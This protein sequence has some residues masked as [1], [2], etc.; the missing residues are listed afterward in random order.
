MSQSSSPCTSLSQLAC[1]VHTHSLSYTA[2]HNTHFSHLVQQRL[3]ALL[4]LSSALSTFSVAQSSFAPLVDEYKSRVDLELALQAEYAELEREGGGGGK[5]GRVIRLLVARRG[6]AR[7]AREEAEKRVVERYHAVSG[8]FEREWEEG[9]KLEERWEV[10]LPFSSSPPLSA[11][12]SARQLSWLDDLHLPFD[13]HDT[14]RAFLASILREDPYVLGSGLAMMEDVSALTTPTTSSSRPPL[15]SLVRFLHSAAGP[16]AVF[17][18][19]KGTWETAIRELVGRE[20]GRGS[21]S[22]VGEQ[23]EEAGIGLGIEMEREKNQNEGEML[24]GRFRRR[25]GQR[26]RELEEMLIGTLEMLDGLGI[27]VETDTAGRALGPLAFTSR[28]MEALLLSF[29]FSASSLPP[30]LAPSTSSPS[31]SHPTPTSPSWSPTSLLHSSFSTLTSAPSFAVRTLSHAATAAS[32]LPSHALNAF[33][34]PTPPPTSSPPPYSFSPPST[35]T[36]ARPGAPPRV[37][38][39]PSSPNKPLPRLP[40][41]PSSPSTL[42]KT[43]LESLLTRTATSLLTLLTPSSSPSSA[44]RTPLIESL[45]ISLLSSSFPAHPADS[46]GTK[47][48]HQKVLALAVVRWWAFKRLGAFLRSPRGFLTVVPAGVEVVLPL[49]ASSLP[50]P[51]AQERGG[52]TP[53][54]ASL[55]LPARAETELLLP[56][57][58]EVYSALSEACGVRSAANEEDVE[59]QDEEKRKLREAVRAFVRG[60]EVG[61]EV[62][63]REED[64]AK[65]GDAAVRVVGVRRE[66]VESLLRTAGEVILPS[67]VS[68]TG[69]DD[70]GDSQEGE[71][72]TLRE[73]VERVVEVSQRTAGGSGETALFYVFR[74]ADEPGEAVVSST[75]PYP[76]PLSIVPHSPPLSFNSSDFSL[77]RRALLLLFAHPSLLPR[78]T[79]PTTPSQ[80]LAA[81]SS[82]SSHFLARGEYAW[83]LL[84]LRVHTLLTASHKPPY[85]TIDVEALLTAVAAPFSSSL[86]YS[87]SLLVLSQKHLT[88]L[89][90]LSSTLTS[91]ARSLIASF[92]AQR[93]QAWSYSVLSSDLGVQ[94]RARL[95]ESRDPMRTE[96]EKESASEEVRAWRAEVGAVA[97]LAGGGEERATEEFEEALML[98]ETVGA[99]ATQPEAIVSSPFFQREAGLLLA[100][101]AEGSIAGGGEEGGQHGGAYGLASTILGAPGALLSSLPLSPSPFPGW[102]GEGGEG[103]RKSVD[104]SSLS[105]EKEGLVLDPTCGAVLPS[106]LAEGEGKDAGATS[107]FQEYLLR[108]STSLSSFL[109][110]DLASRSSSS[111]SLSHPLVVLP[112]STPDN[113]LSL[114]LSPSSPLPLHSSPFLPSGDKRPKALLPTASRPPE[115]VGNLL[116]RFVEHAD[117]EEKVDAVVELEKVLVAL[118]EAEGTASDMEKPQRWPSLTNSTLAPPPLSTASVFLSLPRR[119]HSRHSS[120]SPPRFTLSGAASLQRL[121]SA[122]P[123]SS[124]ATTSSSASSAGG[125]TAGS[126]PS[127]PLRPTFPGAEGAVGGGAREMLGSW[128]YRMGSR[129][130]RRGLSLPGSGFSSSPSPPSS[131]QEDA[132][133]EQEKQKKGPEEAVTTD[134]LLAALEN[135]I[136]HFLPSLLPSSSPPSGTSSSPSASHGLFTTLHTLSSLAPS[137]VCPTHSSSSSS[138]SGQA[139]KAFSDLA[140]ACLAIKADVTD[141]KDGVVETAWE[142]LKEGREEGREEARRL[143][144]MALLAGSTKA[145]DLLAALS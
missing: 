143:R 70:G 130:H 129:R 9:K 7:K 126:L 48:E 11:S 12:A 62:R 21:P 137:L 106:L 121:F 116:R 19:V 49:A 96:E 99:M 78:S 13:A 125:S 81:L 63:G 18:L 95:R 28:P 1:L 139:A 133:K 23:A 144:E 74:K 43:P 2:S 98:L 115:Y 55:A 87:Q 57:H 120:V 104:L 85:S 22:A 92:T 27:D 131:G 127:S 140:V 97:F 123:S 40:R 25:R 47:E 8:A 33:G 88:H 114:L 24:R 53:F 94:L 145:V 67:S 17:S 109:F 103:G 45:L 124:S 36:T 38:S 111:S 14:V 86:T 142:R 61:L 5:E 79:S 118:L 42:A 46:R 16:S 101:A 35:S 107:S 39:S 10:V 56:L 69:W 128:S 100:G 89:S 119:P 134:A 32:S 83:H 138:S 68:S 110:S 31:F 50:P 15:G 37:P 65:E 64:R 54:L 51:P 108:M 76:P 26:E 41:S 132:A 3:V 141:G 82:A 135:A 30:S 71:E 136:L 84:L 6:T 113:L 112:S 93:N 34:L 102:A 58:R 122:Q 90:S 105:L 20:R 4:R 52:K 91:S 72:T 60:L 80:L 117:M 73:K 29:L 77:V 75:F 44:V 66:D 59:G